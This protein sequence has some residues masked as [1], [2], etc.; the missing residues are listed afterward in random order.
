MN[1]DISN[2][3]DSL[4]G[5]SQN[6]EGQSKMAREAQAFLDS[7]EESK[8]R[9]PDSSQTLLEQAQKMEELNNSAKKDLDEIS[10][11]LEIDG[12]DNDFEKKELNKEKIDTNSIFKAVSK[13]VNEEIIG[14]EEFVAALLKA[15]KRP[16][17]MGKSKDLPMGNIIINGKN[18]TGRHC[19]L[20]C[21]VKA[22]HKEKVLTSPEIFTI[23]LALYQSSEQSKVFTQDLFSAFFSTSAVIVFENYDKCHKSLLTNLSELVKSGQ[24][25]LNS[26][27]TM[28]KG[29]LIDVNTA[30]VPNVISKIN[31]KAQYLIFLSHDSSTKIADT[32]GAGFIDNIDDICTTQ[33]FSGDALNEIAKIN[34]KKFTTKCKNLLNFTIE[35]N[36]DTPEI[37]TRAFSLTKGVNTI[38][39]FCDKC[40]DALSNLKLNSDLEEANLN[41]IQ[42]E[43]EIIFTCGNE[44]ISVSL[45]ESSVNLDALEEIKSSLNELVGLS[46]V[47]EYVY[48]LEEN[49]KIQQ[50]RKEQGLKSSG[51]SMHMI[52]TGNPGT[53]KTT[54]ARLVSRYLKNIGVLTGGQLIEVTRADLVGRYVGHTAP[55]TN[56]VINSAI[57]G[58]LF[59]DEAYALC[60]GESDSFGLEA[61]DTLVKGM[62]DNRDNL[63]VIL[64]GYTNEMNEFL[65]SNSGLVSRFPNIIEFPDYTVEEL[66]K[67]TEIIVKSK[68]Y[69]LSDDCK[70]KLVSKYIEMKISPASGNG[71][72][73]RNLV[74]SA[75][76]NQSKRLI[77]EK[78]DKYEVLVA[79]DFD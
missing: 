9:K 70:E 23:D 62:E 46:N 19:A 40:F 48:S 60:R 49:Y 69:V 50:L 44:K 43:N 38:V 11:R 7:L 54:I 28:Q 35:C 1:N 41:C 42:A 15:F 34:F 26:R 67:I 18:G 16:I 3:L 71:R 17:I 20:N 72:L 47:K 33:N 30:L 65:K 52:F 31:C 57:G 74:E 32:M 64:A 76:L 36:G 6:T 78:S 51:T 45:E 56:Q 25:L 2:I 77:K 79:S 61:V 58:V 8:N 21:I 4:F 14:Q 12:F 29:M 5:S 27:Y 10:K 24:L 22:L 53:G 63:I 66:Y 37:F 55:L 75:V 59:I 68:G 73:V 39:E 13:S